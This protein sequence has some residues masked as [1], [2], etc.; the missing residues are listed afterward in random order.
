MTPDSSIFLKK[1]RRLS[2]ALMISGAFNIGVLGFLT[3]WI[4]RERPPT[5]YCDLKP[6]EDKHQQTP[7]ADDRTSAEVIAQL[8]KLPYGHLVNCLERNRLVENGY[9]ERDLALACLVSFHDFDLHRA[10]PRNA[11]PHQQR[12]F[13]WQP[14]SSSESIVITVYPSLTNQQYEA[15]IHF[16]KTE[17]WPMTAQGLFRL[18]KKQKGDSPGDQALIETFMLT[19]EFWTVERLFSRQEQPVPKQAILGLLLEGDWNV[20]KQFVEQQRQRHDLSDARRQKFLLDSIQAGSKSAADLLL[21]SEWDFA[22]KKL[23]DQQAIQVLQL[24]TNKTDNSERFV[25]EMLTSPRST[26]VWRQASALLYNYAGETVPREWNYEAT[27]ARFV[28]DKAVV[29]KETT[30]AEPSLPLLPVR[31]DVVASPKPVLAAIAKP[32]PKVVKEQP[33]PLISKVSAKERS[34]AAVVASAQIPPKA[35]NLHKATPLFSTEKVQPVERTYTVQEGDSLWK[36]AK[37]FG[38]AVDALKVRNQLQS[39]GIKP[40]VVLKIP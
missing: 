34:K 21:K 13:T 2:Q 29:K 30:P 38:V 40:G 4:M 14:N 10:L 16:A 11:Q 8:Y 31:S 26:N 27:L 12:V 5:P 6:A 37:Q 32:I 3:Y 9:A 35:P 25:K 18:L 24:L 22:V 15:I 39:D 19:P 28:P 17:Q 7:L 1:I 23:T 33:A 20:L 36:I